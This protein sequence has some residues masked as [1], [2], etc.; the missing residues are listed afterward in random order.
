MNGTRAQDDEYTVVVAGDNAGCIVTCGRDS[1]LRVGGGDDLVSEQGWLD[2]GIV[3][4]S[5]E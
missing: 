4:S 2:E 1:F 5:C 3:L